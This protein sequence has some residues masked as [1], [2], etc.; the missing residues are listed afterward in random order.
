MKRVGRSSE[1]RDYSP[2]SRIFFLGEFELL[3]AY[4]PLPLYPRRKS[5]RYPFDR[6][7]SGRCGEEKNLELPGTEPKPS[8]PLLYRLSHPDSL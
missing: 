4:T 2:S 3:Y 7:V 1:I 8:E 5:S 6:R